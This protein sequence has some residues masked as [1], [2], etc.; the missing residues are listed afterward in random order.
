MISDPILKK[1]VRLAKRRKYD[2][3]IKLLEAEVFQYR[4][5]Y[6]YCHI[7][8]L[9]CLYAGD[10]G[11]AFD[12]LNRAKNIKFKEPPTLLGLAALFLRREETDRALD[13]YLD[14]QDIDPKNKT[15]K[16]AL[17][18]IRK[19]GGTD[20]LSTW[21]AQ[22]KLASLYPSLPRVSISVKPLPI[23][24]AAVVLAAAT[25]VAIGIKNV[26]VFKRGGLEKSVLERTER[27]KPTETG[28]VYRYILTSEQVISVYEKA[29]KL[30]NTYHDEAAR[31]ELNRILESNASAAVKNKARIL[32]SFLETPGFD[33]L[34]DRFSYA[35]VAA[36]PLLYRGCH[37][38]WRG[39]AANVRIEADK[40]GFEFLV[41]YDT[42]TVME[43]AVA[44]ELDFP[45]EINTV[46]PLEVLGRVVPL[47]VDKFK[48]AGTG[49]HQSPRN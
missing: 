34:K 28:G 42:R 16:K 17:K 12:Y 24:I 23:V 8:G 20:Q 19:Y 13:L 21:L 27:D 22:G 3:S 1:A 15:V 47:S 32:Q 36:D 26:Q 5:S 43:G 35:E 11:G 30:F 44:V 14:I 41:G 39:S 49:I 37:V 45:A 6:G 38:L 9:T 25:V 10:F 31:R 46:E 48:I 2:E 33:T 18:I 40:V 7:L 29:R 4:D